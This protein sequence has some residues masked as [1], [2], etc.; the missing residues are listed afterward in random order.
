MKDNF[1]TEGV[2]EDTRQEI[3]EIQKGTGEYK[4]IYPSPF[5]ELFEYCK[6][7][8]KY[9]TIEEKVGGSL[10][11]LIYCDPELVRKGVLA[12]SRDLQNAIFKLRENEKKVSLDYVASI[13]GMNQQ[14]NHLINYI[15]NNGL[16]STLLNG[17]NIQQTIEK[18][19]DTLAIAH[20]VSRLYLNFVGF[21]INLNNS[22]KFTSKYERMFYESPERFI[23]SLKDLTKRS[24]LELEKGNE[25]FLKT[26][27]HAFE[28]LKGFLDAMPDYG[29]A[30][31]GRNLSA[32]EFNTIIKEV[33]E[34][35][36]DVINR[37][38]S[39]F[40]AVKEIN[41]KSKNICVEF[42]EEKDYPE[43][44]RQLLETLVKLNY[45][46]RIEFEKH[47]TQGLRMYAY[48]L[49]NIASSLADFKRGNADVDLTSQF[50]TV[51]D[52]EH[53]LNS[54]TLFGRVSVN[55]KL[56]PKAISYHLG[57]VCKFLR[58]EIKKADS[59]ALPR[60]EDKLELISEEVY[61]KMIE[62][63]PLKKEIKDT[64][65]KPQADSE[66]EEFKEFSTVRTLLA[67]KEDK[68]TEDKNKPWY[69]TEEGRKLAWGHH[70]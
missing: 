47:T 68:K 41:G 36:V 56:D 17:A 31:L 3:S 63:I 70:D 45:P 42:K 44:P 55:G 60:N 59:D 29:S 67:K 46:Q 43:A 52:I 2:D 25:R 30:F 12:Y 53:A 38:N 66:S 40:P 20:D 50:S 16:D 58:E 35:T 22:N 7:N 54:D 34:I 21:Y 23:E 32:K 5:R 33:K 39:L 27:K 65:E 51:K 37:C 69:A 19:L 10:L 6:A 9:E 24:K 18:M 8:P 28:R 62:D 15:R 49:Y 48:R 11:T 13:E 64:S 61:E 1:A 57:L 14:F 26:N 4:L